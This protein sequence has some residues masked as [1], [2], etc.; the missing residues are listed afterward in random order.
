MFIDL[1]L[2]TMLVSALGAIGA[3]AAVIIL[4]CNINDA[5][6]RDATRAAAQTTSATQALMAAQTQLTIHSTGSSFVTQPELS[7][8]SAPDFVYNDYGGSPPPDTSSY[9]A[10]TTSVNISIPAPIMFFGTSL[11]SGPIFYRKRYVFPIVK[12]HFYG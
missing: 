4:A 10:V 9:V 1:V 11:G 7:S 3:N 5:A 8:S 12:E 6:C 2:T